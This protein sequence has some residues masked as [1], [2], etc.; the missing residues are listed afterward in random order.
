MLMVIS[1][2][3]GRPQHRSYKEL[4]FVEGEFCDDGGWCKSLRRENPT[5]NSVVD[6]RI[7]EEKELLELIICGL[8]LY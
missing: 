4:E 1:R 2:K 7:T 6:G 8:G 3:E 5:R